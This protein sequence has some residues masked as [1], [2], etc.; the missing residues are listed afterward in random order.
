MGNQINMQYI[1]NMQKNVFVLFFF[2]YVKINYLM[3]KIEDYFYLFIKT[4]NYFQNKSFFF[5]A[6]YISIWL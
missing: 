4:K 1:I 3:H 5:V 6:L 2:I